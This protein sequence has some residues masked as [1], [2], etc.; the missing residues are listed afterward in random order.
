MSHK[1]RQNV[2]MKEEQKSHAH[3]APHTLILEGR[4]GRSDGQH[5][6]HSKTTSSYGRTFCFYFA[7]EVRKIRRNLLDPQSN[8]LLKSNKNHTR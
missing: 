2:K 1:K 3:Y 8:A 4:K 5:A 7:A 6:R